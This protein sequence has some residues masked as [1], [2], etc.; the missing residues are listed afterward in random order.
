MGETVGAS[1]GE[2]AGPP[3][4]EPVR[5]GL[6][7]GSWTV[8]LALALT[9]SLFLIGIS[10]IPLFDPDEGR[11]AEI[12]REM[13]ASG[14][15]LVPRLN[16][17]LY[18]EKPPLF[19]WLTAGSSR[20]LPSVEA[21]ARSWS[22]ISGLFGL[23]LA[24]WLGRSV[25]GRGLGLLSAMVLGT[26]P[27][28]VGLA[29]VSAPDM[30]LSA[31]LGATLVCF[32]LARGAAEGRRRLLLW[33]AMFAAAALAVMCK[34]LI[35]LVI[36]GGAVLFFL[37]V[38]GEWAV[39]RAV[40]WVRGIALFLAI[41][42]PWHL[43]VSLR[44][45]SFAWFYFVH[46]HFLRYATPSAHRAA[47]WWLLPVALAVGLL[48]WSGLLPAAALHS[49]SSEGEERRLAQLCWT[50]AAWVVLFFSLSRSKLIPYVLPA[51]LPLSV[52]AAMGLRA[53]IGRRGSRGTL[54]ARA[55]WV[56]STAF[57]ALL[58]FAVTWVARGGVPKVLPAG[59]LSPGVAVAAG[60]GGLAALLAAVLGARGVRRAAVAAA[61]VAAWATFVSLALAAPYYGSLRSTRGAA[62]Y[63]APR[64]DAGASVVAFR[65][66]PQS[67]S[68]YLG[69]LV[70]VVYFP[71]DPDSG[72]DYRG[73]IGFGIEQL[74]EAERLRRFPSME[75]FRRRWTSD[76]PLYLVTDG[77]GFGRWDRA[78]LGPERVVFRSED[79]VVL[80]NDA[81]EAVEG[82][83]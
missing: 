33:L 60:A 83:R 4:G 82:D 30:T 46:E 80:A 75:R 8:W 36:P 10:S 38:S 9:V 62:E 39:L 76:E 7:F 63:L 18:F 17:V 49:R 64:L 42:V 25:G 56:A 69:R 24:F 21:A 79:L 66:Y 37:V 70:D 5:T 11:Y 20:V 52:L 27:L 53:A 72:Q 16:G 19:Y 50:W 34:G 40:P 31:L 32:W 2:S 71:L 15:Y 13:V 41:A 22:V 58:A 59:L 3:G 65:T 6:G 43:A 51:A 28:Y 73:E 26:S 29:H 23:A 77:K 1:T 45:P 61:F 68:A 57:L 55:G 78:D 14:D 54:A 74:P 48:P 44:E 47:P 12:P 67:L 81:A 35:G